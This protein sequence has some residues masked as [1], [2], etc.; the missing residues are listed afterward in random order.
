VS[1][2]GFSLYKLDRELSREQLIDEL[3]ATPDRIRALV[4]GATADALQRRAAPET[5]SPVEVCRHLRDAVQVYGIRFKWMVL[6]ND[7]FLPNYEEE[8][9]VANSPDGADALS[10][11]IDE[12]AAYRAET[13][14]LL[15]ALSMEGWLRPGR[16]E[17]LGPLTLEPY[18]RHELSHEESHLAQLRDSLPA[19]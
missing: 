19:R 4:A 6:Q 11:M 3:A 5:W 7:P 1:A 15:S 14:R 2:A 13:V 10:H 18:V 16:H 8:S 9:W 12:M 17:A